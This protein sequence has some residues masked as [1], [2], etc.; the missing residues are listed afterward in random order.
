MNF[1]IFM[2]IAVI[3]LITLAI[4]LFY[5]NREYINLKG[6]GANRITTR[7]LRRFGLIRGFKVLT[8]V[9][10]GNV[11]I[12]NMLIGYFGILIV[13]TLGAKA[14]FYGTLDSDAWSV[15][16]RG[17]KESIP[18]PVKLMQTE[19][20]ALRGFFSGKKI[21][22]IPIATVVYLSGRSSKFALYVTNGGEILS[23]GKLSAYLNTTKFEKDTGIDVSK[24]VD[25]LSA[26]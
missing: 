17:K 10:V 21:Y 4:C 25:A 6:R 19:A 9:K 16:I 15:V 20:S 7:I 22:N 26:Q 8:N 14:E 3:V 5:L 18:N 13:R 1:Q 24:I 2:V 23:P 12:E 11:V